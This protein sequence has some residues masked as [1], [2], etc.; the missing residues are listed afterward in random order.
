MRLQTKEQ[1]QTAQKA[2]IDSKIQSGYVL[3]VYKGLKLL[4]STKD[5]LFLPYDKKFL[6]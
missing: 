1:R 6:S 3:E 5:N 4:T 2:Q